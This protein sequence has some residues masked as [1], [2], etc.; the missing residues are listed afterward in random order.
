MRNLISCLAVLAFVLTTVRSRSADACG[1]YSPEPRPAVLRLSSHVTH[2]LHADG[3]LTTG[4]RLF[5]LG[6]READHDVRWVPVAPGTF[7]PARVALLDA[8]AAPITLTL[9][10]PRGTRVVRATRT[11]LLDTWSLLRR[12]V[13][14]AHEL[15]VPADEQFAIAVIGQSPSARWIPL[16]QAQVDATTRRAYPTASGV[17]AMN[18][19]RYL[20][21]ERDGQAAT[22]K[23][24]A[25]TPRGAA[26]VQARA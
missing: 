10:G 11:V 2:E 23:L 4:R 5:A 8:A 3:E 13:R 16:D 9:V 6:R 25:V 24:P 1:S 17:L 20:V 19:V 18:G 22:V 7:D 15:D 14:R 21:F 12:D 26:L